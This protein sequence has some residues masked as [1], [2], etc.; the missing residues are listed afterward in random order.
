MPAR[1]WVMRLSNARAALSARSSSASFS[2]DFSVGRQACNWVKLRNLRMTEAAGKLLRRAGRDQ[3]RRARCLQQPVARKIIGE[4]KAGALAADD[5]D[6]AA[7]A[8]ALAGR[9]D[10]ALIHT[11]R[12]RRHRFKIK[13]GVVAAGRERL[14]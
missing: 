8:N 12:G 2:G 14:A 10:Q 1:T 11:Q 3:G 6:A 7:D 9:L 5:A 4:G 13:V